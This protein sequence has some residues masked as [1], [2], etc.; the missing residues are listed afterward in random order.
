[1]VLSHPARGTPSSSRWAASSILT[2][3]FLAL[4]GHLLV[5]AGCRPRVVHDMENDQQRAP[6]KLSRGIAPPRRGPSRSM[7]EKSTAT[8]IGRPVACRLSLTH[9][10]DSSSACGHRVGRRPSKGACTGIGRSGL[11]G[12]PDGRPVWRNSRCASSASTSSVSMRKAGQPMGC[13]GS[14]RDA[15]TNGL[16]PPTVNRLISGLASITLR[17]AI[18]AS[19]DATACGR[20]L[21]RPLNLLMKTRAGSSRV[22]GLISTSLDRRVIPASTR[23]VSIMSP[24]FSK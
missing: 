15:R 8:R 23:L 13:I 20:P 22:D 4:L 19:P 14:G 21:Y 11:L 7:T 1:M 17:A 16:L 10:A 2:Q 12:R 6:T 3:V 5:V 9:L 24:M 18:S